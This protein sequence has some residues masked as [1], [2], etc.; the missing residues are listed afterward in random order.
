VGELLPLLT[1]AERDHDGAETQRGKQRKHEFRPVAD[2]QG[3]AVAG[4]YAVTSHCGG[5]PGHF[6]IELLPA[7]SHIPKDDRLA[8]WIAADSSC[9]QIEEAGR[10]FNK[11]FDD[12][13]AVMRFAARHWRRSAKPG[14]VLHPASPGSV[15]RK[16]IA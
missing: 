13:I 9:K 11:A 14:N 15:L 2:K 7:Y 16:S 8:C 6:P 12:A 5:D 3:N 10:P 4:P 1:D